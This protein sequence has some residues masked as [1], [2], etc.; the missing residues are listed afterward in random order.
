MKN[1]ILSNLKRKISFILIIA[2][3]A[4]SGILSSCA[5]VVPVSSALTLNGVAISNDVFTY[6]TDIAMTELG[7]NADE[8]S[9]FT[10]AI[11]LTETYFKINSLAK[12]VALLFQLQTKRQFLK[13]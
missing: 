2:V 6:F 12:N 3:L 9:I 8:N 7:T 5:N 10:K 11:G 13:K 1:T 4:S